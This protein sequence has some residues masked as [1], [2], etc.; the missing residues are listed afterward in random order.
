MISPKE[1][2]KDLIRKFYSVNAMECKQCALI[3]QKNLLDKL[4]SLNIKD[5]YEENVLSEIQ[6]L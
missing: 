3:A 4:E 1:K 6:K 2:A 5:E